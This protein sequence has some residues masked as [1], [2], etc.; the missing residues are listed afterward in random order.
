MR[1]LGAVVVTHNSEAVIGACLDSIRRAGLDTVV[2]DNASA[3]GTR[4]EV[5]RRP[6]VRLLA[7]GWNRGF[8]AGVNQGVDALGC[9]YVLL[10][11]P[12]TEL[13]SAEGLLEAA[14][15]T[16]AAGA[17][18]TLL[19]HAGRPQIGFNL[20]RLPTPAALS[21]EVLGVNRIWRRNP[22]NRHYRCLDF[23]ADRPSEVEQ[24]AGAF[25]LINTE[26]WRI[27]G[28]F[29][30]GFHPLWFEDVDFAKRA[31]DAGYR[32]HYTPSAAAKHEGGHSVTRL[33]WQ[34]REPYW[35][36]NLLRYAARHFRPL[37]RAGVYGAVVG[38]SS[39]RM[40]L[41]IFRWRSLQPIT[42]YGR[43]IRLAGALF[44][45]GRSEGLNLSS[46]IQAQ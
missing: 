32:I 26:V 24:P 43:V 29:D 13:V 46:A 38:G 27:L 11:N 15:R 45:R 34:I 8:A 19:D 36:G 6:C 20:R 35:Y 10:L 23:P 30:E 39:L 22:I 37:G 3:D 16:G 31:I 41:G 17:C 4:D 5:Q 12:D 40:I 28:G 14:R 25:L 33:P 2:V 7:N 21:L 18:G 44:L 1:A 42:V 9:P